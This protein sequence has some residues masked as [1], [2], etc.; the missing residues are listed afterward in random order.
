MIKKTKNIIIFFIFCV[1][2]FY[3]SFGHSGWF[4]LF[5]SK[6]VDKH[7]EDIPLKEFLA[8]YTA[9]IKS[10]PNNSKYVDLFVYAYNLLIDN[11]V[12]EIPKEKRKQLLEQSKAKILEKE[13]LT[14]KN[15]TI[16]TAQDISNIALYTLYSGLD[17]HT[18]WFNPEDN[19][20][21]H[22][23]ID[24]EYKGIGAVLSV[25]NNSKYIEVLDV[26]QNSPAYKAGLKKGD[27]IYRINGSFF[28]SKH[29]QEAVTFIKSKYRKIIHIKILR[30]KEI[31]EF[32]IKV[33]SF[34]IESVYG[35]LID[36]K[37]AYIKIS[38]FNTNTT[39][40]FRNVIKKLK[41]NKSK[42]IILD[43][44]GNPGGMLYSSLI[45]SD[46]FLSKSLILSVK[47]RDDTL[48]LAY[49]ATSIP[50]IKDN[51]PLVILTNNSTAS[52]AEI[53]SAALQQNH[54]AIIMGSNTF[55]KGSVQTL[56][57]LKDGSSAKITIQLFYTP[58][59]EALQGYGVVPNIIIKDNKKDAF[60]N[61]RENS[62]NNKII[63]HH[64]KEL[65]KAD[66]T[67]NENE[68]SVNKSIKDKKISC[69]IDYFSGLLSNIKR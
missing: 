38:I 49:Y 59:G 4:G 5:K 16:L 15:K 47:G 52:A 39:S 56:Y 51:I 66:F 64:K 23:D 41:L 10:T 25:K 44:R 42:G 63:V 53:V 1:L 35:K 40:E 65:S 24:G 61:T 50:F 31:K 32:S 20:K 2:I 14:I 27:L 6:P 9:K 67:I 7:I 18:T 68:C 33:D 8:F 43:L 13:Q 48:N 3:P 45:I 37:Y 69:A 30:N 21:F 55:G 54:R 19:K 62:F 57:N 12:Y 26:I 29:L 11:Y 17:P 46:M 58:N 34:N 22:A 60:V 36:N 28:N